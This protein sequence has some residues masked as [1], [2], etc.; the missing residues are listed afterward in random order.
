MKFCVPVPIIPQ[1]IY[2]LRQQNE[3]LD[4]IAANTEAGNISNG[5]ETIID[6][7]LKKHLELANENQEVGVLFAS[8]A[9]VQLVANPFVGKLTNRYHSSWILIIWT[10]ESYFVRIGY[11]VPMFCGF[12]IMFVSTVSE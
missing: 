12:I 9:F 8:K 1:F 3:E 11:T 6:P 4:N 2:E 5:N 10:N 7:S